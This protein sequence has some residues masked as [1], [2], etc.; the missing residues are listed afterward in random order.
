MFGSGETRLGEPLIVM[1]ACSLP[2]S[3]SVPSAPASLS[4]YGQVDLELP[5]RQHRRRRRVGGERRAGGLDRGDPLR[6]LR[7]RRRRRRGSR[8]DWRAWAAP[9][10]PAPGRGRRARLSRVDRST[11]TTGPLRVLPS[12]PGG[13]GPA[14]AGDRPVERLHDAERER[15]ALPGDPEVERL[16]R[17]GEPVA[18]GTAPRSTRWPGAWRASR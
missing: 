13:P 6:I 8:P 12:V 5:A 10:R 16:Q 7:R 9:R 15:P 11:S 1:S 17:R 18:C 14:V 3:T 4:R 2:P